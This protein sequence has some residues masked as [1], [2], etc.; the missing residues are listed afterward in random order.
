M[1]S[2]KGNG[3]PRFYALLERMAE[4][5][6]AKNRDYAGDSDPLRNLRQCQD[7]GVDPWVGVIVR[8]TDKMDRLKS[9]A[10]ARTYAVK[11]EGIA[12]TL[13]DM[14][15]YSLLCLILFEESDGQNPSD[16][17]MD[18]VSEYERA[19]ARLLKEQE[20]VSFKAFGT[21]DSGP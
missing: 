7:A 11:D 8:L 3:H 19:M 10:K 13:I 12:D 6:S 17:A 14:A 2:L 18:A 9:F 20:L 5:H 4:V 21:S 15:N 1:V 16:A